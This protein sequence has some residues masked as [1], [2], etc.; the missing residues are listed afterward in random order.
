M[1]LQATINPII[2]GFSPDPSIV[3]VE[4]WYYL[5]NSSFHMF[6]GLPIYASQDLVSWKHIGNAIHRQS[7][8]SLRKSD[9]RFSP[10]PSGDIMLSS[11]GLFAPTIRYHD[12]TF[13]VVCTNLL[14]PKPDITENFIVS[15]NDIWKGNWSDPVYFKFWGIDPSIFFDDDGRAYMHGSAAPGPMTKIHLFEI[16]LKTGE[17]L[18]EEKKIWDGTGGIF[19]EGPHLYKKDGWYYVMISEGGTHENHMITI[20]RSKDIWGPYEPCPKN[21]ILTATGTEEYIQYTGHCDLFQDEQ[22]SWWG[23]C[24]GVRKDKEGRY[25]MGRESFLTPAEWDDEGWLTFERVKPNPRGVS[26]KEGVV[27]LSATPGVDWLYIRDADLARY[28]FD[29]DRISVEL[30]SSAF[31]FSDP[32]ESPTFVGK[33]QRLLEGV[34]KATLHRPMASGVVKA[35]LAVYK[36]EHRFARIF[37]ETAESTAGFELV[38][39][40]RE[41]FRSD[42]RRVDIAEKI[43]FQ[44]RYTESSY[45]LWYDTHGTGSDQGT[46]L[47]TVDTLNLTDPDFVGPVIGVFADGQEEKVNFSDITI[48]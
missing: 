20:A 2:P 5:V 34:S 21:P 18:S 38:N 23:V 15:T 16:D 9:T 29:D 48:D 44:I 41:I 1:T 10:Q 39:G 27:S 31:N 42:L 11:G 24:L 43:S 33:R 17:K 36:E 47:A 28:K 35:G 46:C 8:L 26:R 13:Y 37:Y 32:K 45:S 22:G 14:H 6:P 4:G 40:A 3:R 7:Q 30:T 19:P 25:I 12:G